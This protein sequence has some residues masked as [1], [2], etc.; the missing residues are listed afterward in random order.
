MNPISTEQLL[1]QLKWRYATKKFDTTRKIPDETWAALE[2]TLILTPSSYGLQPWKFIVI[3]KQELKEELVTASYHQKQVADCSHL[4]VLAGQ[5]DVTVDDVD[6]LIDTIERIQGR[7]R[8]SIAGYRGMMISDIVEG[9]RSKDVAGWS[10][11]Q[12]YI[13]LGNLMTTAALLGVDACPMEGFVPAKYDE[14][15]D[16]KSKG[17]TAAVVC[18]LGYRKDD[19]AYAKAPKVRYDTADLIERID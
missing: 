17:L 11:L 12:C 16:L 19:D 9:P 15:L 4:V 3:T 18:P 10:K 5:L 6:K 13:A 7:S 14:L 1:S 2:E 8:E